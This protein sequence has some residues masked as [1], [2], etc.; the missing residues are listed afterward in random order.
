MYNRYV[1]QPDGSFRRNRVPDQSHREHQRPQR[2]GAPKPPVCPPP[3]PEQCVPPPPP[4]KKDN[5]RKQNRPQEKESITG[6]F[7]N[8]LPKDLD[9]ADLLIILLLLVMAGDC[10]EDKNNALLTLALYFLL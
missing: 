10:E 3:E 7:K 6:F 5:R 9:T 8:L 2:Q 4:P 1:P